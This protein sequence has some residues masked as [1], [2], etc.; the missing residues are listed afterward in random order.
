MSRLRRVFPGAFVLVAVAALATLG[1]SAAGVG[2]PLVF[3]IVVGAL[4]AN[5]FGVP[6][7]LEPGLA[8][9]GRL[10]EVGIVLLG[11]TMGFDAIA[12]SGPLV[13]ALVAA[14]VLLGVLVTETAARLTGLGRE[15]RSLLAAGASVCGVSAVVT[16]AGSIDAS[17]ER[18]A[19]AAATVLLFDA[20]TLVA[21]PILGHAFSLSGREFG[22]WAGLAMFSTGPVTAAGFA[23]GPVAGRWATITKLVRNTAIGVLAVAYSLR[24]N[25]DSASLDA[26][27]DGI[28]VFLVGFFVV[29]LVANSGV[30][31]AP[32]LDGAARLSDVCFLLAFAGLGFDVRLAS[33][34]DAG[35]RPVAAVATSLVVV[36]ALSLLAVQ[37]L[38]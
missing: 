6:G 14:A 25:D 32:A 8:L 34:R 27:V 10:L 4:V 22:V 2:S 11:A 18:V 7:F 20:V 5:T 35:I 28:P 23:Y 29:A 13:L 19:Y 31:P 33:M 24:D 17:E 1:A 37:T 30:V 3:A 15:A 9:H 16:V 12:E 36:S 21:F 26:L 38:L